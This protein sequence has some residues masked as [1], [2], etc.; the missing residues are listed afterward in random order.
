MFDSYLLCSGGR[1]V[2]V[3][4]TVSGSCV[5]ELR[6]HTGLVTSIGKYPANQFQVSCMHTCV[7]NM[8]RS[9]IS[10]GI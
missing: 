9:L 8:P 1:I 6:G 7:A 5:R 3:Y 10:L 4:S 2:K